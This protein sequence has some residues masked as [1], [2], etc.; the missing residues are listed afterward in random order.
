MDRP[1]YYKVLGVSKDATEKDIKTAYRRLARKYHPDVNPGEKSAKGRFK[2]IGEAYE[3]LS[4]PA[5]RKRYDTLG[6]DWQQQYAGAGAPGGTRTY[7][8]RGGGGGGAGG[9]FGQDIGGFSDFFE[10]IFGQMGGF[11]GTGSRTSRTKPRPQQ[12]RD[13]E[14]YIDVTLAEAYAGSTRVIQTPGSEP[15]RQCSGTGEITPES[16]V[17]RLR[18]HGRHGPWQAHRSEDS[19]GVDNGSKICIAGEGGPGLFGGPR[20]DLFLV[21]H[22][23]PDQRF[24]RKGED[25]ST[26]VEVDLLTAMLGGEAAVTTPDNRASS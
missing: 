16:Q 23:V 22:Y 9:P 21:V 10:T 14:Q 17:P 19:A 7:T 4:D 8:Y 13:I 20:G 25:L 18:R 3:V 1:D 2:E 26:E 11:P 5:K 6:P 15:C 24:E 12:G